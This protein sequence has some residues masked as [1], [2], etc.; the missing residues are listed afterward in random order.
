M[1]LPLPGFYHPDAVGTLYLE[2]AALVADAAQAHA[3]RH[4]IRPAAE[5][6][7]KVC[8]FGVDAQV[9]FCLPG[10]SLYVP[11]AVEDCR[12]AVE[13]LYRNLDRVTGLVFTLDTHTAFQVFHPPWWVDAEGK[14]PPPFTPISAADVLSGRWRPTREPERT[15]A[16]VQELERRGRY[17]LTVWPYHALQGGVSHA[18][19]PAVMEASLFHAHARRSPTHFEAKGQHP[20]T[21]HYSV[22]APEVTELAGETLG[23]FN[24]RLLDA[25]LA[26]DRVYIFGEAKSHC[27]LF[28]VRDILEHIRDVDP[29]LARRIYLLE[30][31]MSPVAPPPIEPLPDALDFPRLADQAMDAFAR[32]GVHRVKTTDPLA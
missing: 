30:D 22:F 6:R 19:M 12:R 18:L 29:S 7:E 17:L 16:Y 28:S 8:L 20:L 5:D 10:A 26:Y 4:G 27:V 13:W 23:A 3:R 11:G 1:A 24:Q 9:T 15:L 25:L 31:A 14:H 32:A 21:E 2:R